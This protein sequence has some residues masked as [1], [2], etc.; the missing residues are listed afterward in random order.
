MNQSPLNPLQGTA[1][2]TTRRSSAICAANSSIFGF[3]SDLER[4]LACIP[5]A[6]RF[7]LDKSRIKLSLD[8]W[9][10]LPQGN[11]RNLLNIRCESGAEIASFRR[12]LEVLIKAELGDEPR[13]LEDGSD[14]PW[15]AQDVP[16]QVT[17]KTVELGCTPPTASQW[18]ALTPLERFALLKLSRDGDHSRNLKPALREFGLLCVGHAPSLTR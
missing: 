5:L 2:N 15:D 1:E 12:A 17:Q 11:R 4:S 18:R 7:K 8:Q 10:K 3:E 6:V 9:R 14:L 13:R 16:P